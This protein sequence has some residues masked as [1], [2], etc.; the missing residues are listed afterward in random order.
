MAKDLMR[1]TPQAGMPRY[2]HEVQQWQL[3]VL[4]QLAA[5]IANF[6]YHPLPKFHFHLYDTHSDLGSMLQSRVASCVL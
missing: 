5:P 3:T 2:L 1:L 4:C 6:C